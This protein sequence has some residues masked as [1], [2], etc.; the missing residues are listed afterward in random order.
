[1]KTSTLLAL[2]GAAWFLYNHHNSP[3]PDAGVTTPN[4]PMLGVTPTYV[5]GQWQCSQGYPGLAPN[6]QSMMCYPQ[7]NNMIN[8]ADWLAGD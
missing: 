3:L 4:T 1:M 6:A 2:A 8:P 7:P 5:N